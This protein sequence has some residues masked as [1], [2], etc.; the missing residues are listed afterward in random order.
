MINHKIYI[1]VMQG[2]SYVF[3]ASTFPALQQEPYLIRFYTALRY[4]ARKCR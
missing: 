1:P 3:P 2:S 4:A